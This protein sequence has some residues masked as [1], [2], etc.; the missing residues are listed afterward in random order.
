MH[1]DRRAIAEKRQTV[2]LQIF[3]TPLLLFTY[4]F[5]QMMDEDLE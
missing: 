2:N 5:F 4:M 3:A 1:Y